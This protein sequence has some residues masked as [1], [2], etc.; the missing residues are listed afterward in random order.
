MSRACLAMVVAL[1]AGQASAQ[2]LSPAERKMCIDVCFKQ[3]ACG[4]QAGNTRALTMCS[5][6]CEQALLSRLPP[7]THLCLILEDEPSPVEIQEFHPAWS[8][9]PG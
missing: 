4:G 2:T 7:D 6:G 1:L 9:E 5:Q 8:L 3:L